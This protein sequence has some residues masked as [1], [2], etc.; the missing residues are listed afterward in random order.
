MKGMS[1][2]FG[3]GLTLLLLVGSVARADFVSWSYQASGSPVVASD[4]SSSSGV[5][6]GYDP[7]VD[8]VGNSHIAIANLWTFSDAPSSSPAMFTHAGYTLGLQLTDA[9]SGQSGSVNLAGE[10]NGSL[11]AK[12]ALLTNTY[13]G[14]AVQHLALGANLYT[15]ALSGFAPPGPPVSG[16]GGAISALITVQ[17]NTVPEPAALTLAVLGFAGLGFVTWRR[18]KNTCASLV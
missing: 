10:L 18:W 1:R 3:T 6:F 13:L 12:S 2:L 5:N 7:K 11:S 8:V 9:A 15:V 14:N 17:P 16:N 4:G